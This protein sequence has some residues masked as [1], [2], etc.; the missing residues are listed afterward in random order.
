C[1]NDYFIGLFHDRELLGSN[2]R[3]TAG[4][5]RFPQR[6]LACYIASRYTTPLYLGL[7]CTCSYGC[8]SSCQTQLSFRSANLI[9]L[10]FPSHRSKSR[11]TQFRLIRRN[12][13]EP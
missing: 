6:P 4:Q 12:R 5:T 3:C 9:S 13:T 1:N 11:H 8:F 2:L 10:L 7:I